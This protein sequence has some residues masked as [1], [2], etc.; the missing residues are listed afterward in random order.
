MEVTGPDGVV[1]AA[2]Q[3]H[4]THLGS[5]RGFLADVVPVAALGR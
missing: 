2:E 3:V 4:R 5:L 1:I